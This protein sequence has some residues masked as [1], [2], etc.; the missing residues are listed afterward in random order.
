MPDPGVWLK[1]TVAPGDLYHPGDRKWCHSRKTAV[2]RVKTDAGQLP[3]MLGAGLQAA[4][5]LIP[6]A[7]RTHRAARGGLPEYS[8]VGSG[9]LKTMRSSSSYMQNVQTR[10]A[11]GGSPS[12][13]CDGSH[14]DPQVHM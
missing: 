4:M 7:D 13:G 9:S 14:L 1:V 5:S 12:H 2:F 11:P 3:G 8:R 6:E 10:G